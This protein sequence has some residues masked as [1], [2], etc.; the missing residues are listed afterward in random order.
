MKTCLCA[1]LL[2][3]AF[4]AHAETPT[5]PAPDASTRALEA[6]EKAAASAQRAAEAAQLAAE[7]AAK[8]AVAAEKAAST[9]AAAL[10]TTA[11]AGSAAKPADAPKLPDPSKTSTWTGL[12]GIGL[13][14][15][16]GNS[17]A[18]TFKGTAALER[19]T[20]SWI[21]GVKAGPTAPSTPRSTRWR[22]RSRP[23]AIGGSRPRSAASS[24]RARRPTTS[25]RSSTGPTAKAASASSGGT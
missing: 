23:A 9:P 21:Y 20:E 14:A 16:T 13:I 17:E 2:A 22:P 4:A 5:S 12:V 6:M 24:S 1:L 11:A 8:S 3:A 25:S 18:V 15:L 10:A 7:A 19:K